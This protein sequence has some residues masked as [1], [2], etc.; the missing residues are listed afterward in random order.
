VT[1]ASPDA[2]LGAT[3]ARRRCPKRTRSPS[4]SFRT[5]APGLRGAALSARCA[6]CFEILASFALHATTGLRL[7]DEERSAHGQALASLHEYVASCHFWFE[8]FQNWQSEFL[9]VLAIVVLSIFLREKGSPESKPVAAPHG[10]TGG[11]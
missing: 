4:S 5:G 2:S 3:S 8:S 6:V 10:Q 1:R 9:A 7:Y 11:V